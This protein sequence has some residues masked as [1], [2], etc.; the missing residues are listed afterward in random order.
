MIPTRT[1][2][3]N[4]VLGAPRDWDESDGHCEG[5]P[6]AVANGCTFSYW[7]PS[8]VEVLQILRGR[9]IRLG[10]YGAHP[11]VTVDMED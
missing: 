10:V 1:P 11:P 2:A 6:V 9:P 3:T 7:R 8:P 4:T 5:L